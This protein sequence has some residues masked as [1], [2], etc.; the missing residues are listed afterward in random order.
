[1]LHMRQV[2]KMQE[3]FEGRPVSNQFEVEPCSSVTQ[4]VIDKSPWWILESE[5][6]S[7]CGTR[8]PDIELNVLM[9]A[10]QKYALSCIL[11]Q[12]FIETSVR[13]GRRLTMVV[14]NVRCLVSSARNSSRQ[15]FG[16]AVDA[17]IRRNSFM[18]SLRGDLAGCGVL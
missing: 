14:I 12:K 10:L 13:L 1:M 18:R 5:L 8:N 7:Y 17:T 2:R 16:W 3:N 9:A 11:R 6:G 15:V 4:P